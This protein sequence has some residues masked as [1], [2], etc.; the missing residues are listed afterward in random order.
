MALWI[1]IVHKRLQGGA[2]IGKNQRATKN[3]EPLGYKS[4]Q[5]ELSSLSKENMMSEKLTMSR[6]NFLKTLAAG[7]AVAAMPTVGKAAAATAT[8]PTTPNRVRAQ[9]ITLK[10]D[11]WPVKVI[12]REDIEANPAAGPQKIATDAWL[13]QNPDVELVQVDRITDREAIM[14]AIIG[15]TAPTFLMAG[16]VGSW[17][18]GNVRT[19]YTQ[20]FFADI[21]FAIEEQGLQDRVLPHIWDNWAGNS[22]IDGAF[23]MYPMNEYTPDAS[24]LQYRLDLITELGLQ[25]PEFGWSW[26]EARE[27]I[28]ALTD[29]SAGRFGAGWPTWF[30]NFHNEMYGSKILTQ[31][32]KPDSAWHWEQ[33]YMT[34]P[35][36][37]EIIEAYRTMLFEDR[38]LLSDVALGGGDNEYFNLF[39]AGQIAMGRF[40]YW[41]MFGGAADPTSM[42]G[43]ARREGKPFEEMFGVVMLPTGDGYQHGGGINTWGPVGFDP[44]ADNE[45]LS[46]AVD[47]VD[48]MY[49]GGGLDMVKAGVWEFTEDPQSVWS[50]FLYMD[51]RTE[52]EGVPVT[53]VDAWGEKLVERWSSIGQY[54]S[55]PNRNGY[56]PTEENPGP[57]NQ[58]FD[59]KFSLFVT[60]EDVD[61]AA[62]LAE[63][64]ENWLAQAAEFESSVSADDFRAAALAYYADL[65][66]YFSANYPEFHANRYAPFYQERVLPEIE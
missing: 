66:A 53:P 29:E 16:R 25:E 33:D 65:D 14:T 41:K 7:A 32:P 17:N 9:T 46:K 44:N 42:A 20:G 35:R 13:D 36:W 51:G 1:L 54:P 22:S 61:V 12:T 21:S 59:D 28:R 3:R 31:L 39:H 27:L 37:V 5:Q 4:N 56:F 26:E 52:F 47:L 49:F 8:G 48:W 43:I 18:L 19:A 60:E 58:A 10:T 62:Q 34:D 11:G 50:A 23:F 2:L 63:G 57:N 24:V 30:L 6:R 64:Q 38:S 45:T 40:N 55:E 15:G